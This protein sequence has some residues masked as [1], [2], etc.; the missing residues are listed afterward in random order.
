MPP[1]SSASTAT[2]PL[3]GRCA[4]TSPSG[5]ASKLTT[6]TH[7]SFLRALNVMSIL[8]AAAE[9]ATAAK[10]NFAAVV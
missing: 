8:Q 4:F 6:A 9:R 1:I 3:A 7:S 10:V 5:V 2:L